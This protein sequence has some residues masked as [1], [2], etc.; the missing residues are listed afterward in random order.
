MV[1]A[2]VGVGMLG[3]VSTRA[4]A[5]DRGALASDC[6]LPGADA[7]VRL[8]QYRGKVVYLDFWASWCGPCKQSFPWMNSLQARYGA[9]G[10]QVLAINVDARRDD[11]RKFL[12][13]NPAAF[14][15]AYDGQGQTPRLYDVKTMPS[16]YVIDRA[17]KLSVLHRGFAP[18]DTP[19]LEQ[20]IRLALE[21]AA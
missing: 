12:Q 21:R 1:R 2:A 18:E 7:A 10:L 5:L 19:G 13:S 14:T 15:V 3:A 11:A 17:G 8:S 16:S 20:A 9:Q 6:E 4:R